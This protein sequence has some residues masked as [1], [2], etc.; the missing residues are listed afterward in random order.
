[1][2]SS[3][4]VVSACLT[5]RTHWACERRPAPEAVARRCSSSSSKATLCKRVS[6]L[7]SL[8]M[9]FS[10]VL[11]SATWTRAC[12]FDGTCPTRRLHCL[13]TATQDLLL[14]RGSS[15]HRLHH[16]P[17]TLLVTTLRHFRGL[18]TAIISLPAPFSRPCRASRRLA[19]HPL[20]IRI[21]IYPNSLALTCKNIISPSLVDRCRRLLISHRGRLRQLKIYTFYV[22][23]PR[24]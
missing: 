15:L 17:S 22:L 24:K 7:R 8:R 14:R 5:A 6:H 10:L 18:T 16:L 13:R 4:V 9:H 20:R 21:Q 19:F 12:L 1:M 23:Q 2:G 3:K 11:S